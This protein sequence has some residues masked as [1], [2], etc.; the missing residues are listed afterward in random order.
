LEEQERVIRRVPNDHDDVER[1]R[2]DIIAAF[3]EMYREV[4]P[5]RPLDDTREQR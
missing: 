4:Y 3:Q 2:A 1:F 5:D